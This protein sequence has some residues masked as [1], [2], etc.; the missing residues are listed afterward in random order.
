MYYPPDSILMKG[1]S[2]G[3]LLQGWGLVKH[4][5]TLYNNYAFA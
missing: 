5:H 1:Y 4:V 2:S 3:E